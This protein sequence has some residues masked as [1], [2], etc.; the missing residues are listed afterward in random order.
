MGQIKSKSGQGGKH[1]KAQ[2]GQ[3]SSKPTIFEQPVFSLQNISKQNDYSFDTCT[4]AEKL[5]LINRLVALSKMKWSA[6]HTED[7]HGFGSE[8][9]IIPK[10]RRPVGTPNDRV[11][12]ALRFAPANKAF[13]GY[14]CDENIFHIIWIDKKY[15]LYKH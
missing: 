12:Y 5:S 9:V 14:K 11:Y 13:I 10:E 6:I 4:D 3:G 7:R 2:G 1:I 15:S 8:K